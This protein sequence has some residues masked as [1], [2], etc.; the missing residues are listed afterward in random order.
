MDRKY[1]LK[2]DLQFRCNNSTMKFDEFDKNTSDFFI[3]V[4]RGNKLID[5]S[6]AIVTLAVIKPDKTAD[7]QFVE[8]RDNNVY[9][10][11]KSSMKDIPG[12]YEAIAS[13]VM[14]N[15]IV[16]T[17]TITYEVAENK[18]LKQ[19][20][21]EVVSE[22]KFTIL[23]DMINRL[24][25]I[26]NSEEA[27]KLAEL[28]REEAEKQREIAKQQLIDQVNK[29]IADTNSKVDDNLLENSNKVAKLISDTTTIIDDYKLSK[30]EAIQQDLQLYKQETTENI[31]T[32]KNDKNIEIDNYKNAK[33]TEI[34][35]N[36]SDYKNS[37]TTDIETYKNSKDEELDN[38]KIEKDKSIDSYVTAKNKELDNYKL[39]KNTE[40]NEFKDLKDAEINAKLEEVDTAEQSRTAAEQQRVTDHADRENFLNSFESQLG[41]IVLKNETQ[42]NRLN[43][44][45]NNLGIGIEQYSDVYGIEIDIPNNKFTRLAGAIGKNAGTDFDG[46]SI[47]GNRKRCIVADDTT[48]LAFYGEDGYIETGKLEVEII[49]NDITYHIGTPVQVMVQQPK[50]YYKRVPIKVEPIQNGIGYHLRHW[51]DYISPYPKPGFKLHPNFLRNGIEYDYILLPAYE[52]SIYDVSE[53]KQL[54][55]DEQICDFTTDKLCS[56]A[57]SKPCSGKTQDLTIVNSRKIANNRGQGWQLLDVT[58]SYAD[59]MLMSIEYASFDFQTVIGQGVVSIQDTPNTENNSILT[60]GTSHLGN[61]SGMAEG[62]NGQ[63]SVSYRGRENPWGNMWKWIDGLN[64]ECKG[65]HQAYWANSNF[66]SGTKDNYKNCGFT[67]AK[68]NGYIS[69]VGYSTENDF[70][71]IPTETLGASNR[72]LNDYYY[73]NNTYNGFFVALLGGSWLNGSSA[74]A[75]SLSVF[76]GSGNRHR[77]IGAGL[78]CIPKTK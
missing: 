19:L 75:C 11:L 40:I 67:L 72:P 3:R 27:R 26:E 29:L 59:I 8:I 13:I 17:D 21:T 49:K 62:V 50:F 71:Y 18:I 64:I 73:Q 54:L 2:L 22:E 52:G 10:D 55:N 38:Y 74:G 43:I 9:C 68:T 15:E 45:E 28:S 1:N 57:N 37:T 42:D 4:T 7:A 20:N 47:F 35:K 48:I 63:V 76:N 32:Y 16:I 25:V 53:N 34:N 30:D 78:L 61:V 24:S 58:S 12:K 31:N 60:G 51:H 23:T 14:N 69:A 77:S 56:I 44:V 36:L 70:M 33:D 41:Q 46:V 39:A 6:K 5:I 65:I 66:K